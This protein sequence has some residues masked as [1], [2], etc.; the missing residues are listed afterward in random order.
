MEPFEALPSGINKFGLFHPVEIYERMETSWS[1]DY[2][3][4]HLLFQ[5][6]QWKHQNNIQNL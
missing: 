3:S 5:S 4:C 2:P 6:Q 1:A